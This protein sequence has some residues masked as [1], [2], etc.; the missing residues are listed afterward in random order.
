MTRGKDNGEVGTT[1]TQEVLGSTASYKVVEDL[2]DTVVV[3]VMEAPGLEPGTRLRLKREALRGMEQVGAP[4]RSSSQSSRQR[5]VRR[6]PASE[7]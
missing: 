6:L 1:W 3:A 2:G 4:E 7:H 5:S